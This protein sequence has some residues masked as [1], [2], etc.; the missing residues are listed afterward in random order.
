MSSPPK[1]PKPR[2]LTQEE[3]NAINADPEDDSDEFGDDD[4]LEVGNLE[5]APIELEDDDKEN[6]VTYNRA[7][8]QNKKKQPRVPRR[9]TRQ[10]AVALDG[11]EPSPVASSLGKSGSQDSLKRK[12]QDVEDEPAVT[13]RQLGTPP[14]ATQEEDEMF[15]KPMNFHAPKHKYS[16]QV[17][18]SFG[19][20]G[21]C[22]TA[23]GS[24]H[25]LT[26]IQHQSLHLVLQRHQIANQV[27]CIRDDASTR[28][29]D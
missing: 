29:N 14:Q 8:A 20:Q 3:L 27:R 17:R 1:P 12:R 18:S 19:S 13:K 4:L 15:F 26:C 22:Q 24:S 25:L 5:D 16:S 9:G 2:E 7:V 11:K 23:C 28:G 21:P 6:D 10:Q